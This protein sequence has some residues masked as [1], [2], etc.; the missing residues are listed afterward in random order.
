MFL[1]AV[2]LLDEVFGSGDR[3]IH[4]KVHPFWIVVIV[5]TLQYGMTEALIAAG[6]AS[7]F[8]LAWHMPEQ[9]LSET[10]YE[11]LFR[12]LELPLLWCASALVLGG[13]RTRQVHEK[14]ALNDRAN[15][16]SA[17]MQN[18][19]QAYRSVKQVKEQL[20]LRLASERC[21]MLTV[22]ELAKS[23]ETRDADLAFAGVD[24]L[25]CGALNPKKFSIYL[26]NGESLNL[27][28]QTGWQASDSFH[29]VFDGE[30]ALVESLIHKRQAV[31]SVTHEEDEQILQGQGMLAGLMMDPTSG[32]VH[33]MLKI[34]EIDFAGLNLHTH[35]IF[36]VICE[37]IAM[38]QSNLIAYREVEN[39]KGSSLMVPGSTAPFMMHR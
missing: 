3:M 16:A 13:I 10:M 32:A 5:V 2:V 21:S 7:V 9:A 19:T 39:R 30:S 1:V 36:R 17:A 34:E 33:G 12:M 38:V 31:L 15:Q 37:W 25:I 28:S 24:R 4:A 8:L 22:F 35:E 29:S 20:E 6:M 27:K 23:L 18:M 11:H 26:W 14:D